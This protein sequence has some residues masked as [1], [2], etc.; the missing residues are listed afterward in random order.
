MEL[1]PACPQIEAALRLFERRLIE[2]EAHEGNQLS[3]RSL[4]VGKRAVVRLAESGMPI[5]LVER[6]DETALDSVSL[7]HRRQLF[8]RAGHTINVGPEMNMRVE[9]GGFRGKLAAKPRLPR[10]DQ[11]LG[12]DESFVHI[13]ESI[14][15]RDDSETALEELVSAYPV[16]E[17]R[18]K[19]VSVYV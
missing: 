13:E 17:A 5:G 6:E 15:A 9:N 1:Y 19:G 10:V 16:R 11:H 3:L 18:S 2:I 4:G 14:R 7:A 8:V 12:T